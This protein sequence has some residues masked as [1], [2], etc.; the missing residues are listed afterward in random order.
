MSE[1]ANPPVRPPASQPVF[2]LIPHT[3]WDREWYLT[4]AEF[5]ARLVPVMEDLLAGLERDRTARCVLDGQTILLRD[6]L[7]TAP[8]DEARIAALVARG[9]LEIGPW[10]VL[11]DLLIPSGDSLRKNLELGAL[12]CARFGRRLE[13]LYS[14]DAFGH[15]GELPALA[16][17]F[18]L[19]RA[20]IRRGL[21]R[22]GG[23]DLDRYRWTTP[24]G[25]EVLVHHLPAGGYDIAIDL[26]RPSADLAA[27]WAALRNE[28]VARAGGGEVAV[29]LGAD[30]HAVPVTAPVLAAALRGIDPALEIRVSGLTEYF[31]ALEGAGPDATTIQGELR[32]GDGHTWVLPGVHSARAR[33]K[34][35]HGD[36]ELQL[37]RIAEPL[38]QL[39]HGH[40]GRDQDGLLGAAWRTLLECQFHDT[41]AGTTSDAVQ[42]EQEVRLATVQAIAG[43]VTAASVET[44]TGVDPDRIRQTGEAGVLAEWNPCG[45]ARQGIRTAELVFFRRDVLVGAPSGRIP[46]QGAGFAG[47]TLVTADGG[48]LPIQALGVQR[49]QH[50][51]DAMYAY[52]DQ[53]EVDR[54]WIAYAGQPIRG[55]GTG[56]LSPKPGP[57][58]VPDLL[59][60]AEPGV[61]G[62]RYIN[63]RVARNGALTIEDKRNGARLGELGECTDEADAGDLYTFSSGGD[64]PIRGGR[65]VSQTVM[66]AGPLVGAM[67]TRWEMRS[68]GDGEIRIRQLV[69]VY[70]DSPIVRIRLEIE[71]EATGHRLRARF[72]VPGAE[73]TLAGTALGSI[74]RRLDL[75]EAQHPS[76]YLPPAAPAHRYVA[77]TAGGPG[78]AVLSPGF[79]E[80]AW[81]EDRDVSVTLLR[82]VGEL[83]RDGLPERPGHAAWPTATP[84]AQEPGL[85]TIHLALVP[86][87]ASEAGD[88]ARLEEL[89]EDAFLPVQTWWLGPPAGAGDVKRET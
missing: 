11:S 31:E 83:S 42:R 34:R 88:V 9:A 84:D 45:R 48:M 59:L 4:R 49:G 40:G 36:V 78:V 65:P 30:H 24:G 66:A 86:I 33:L 63:V 20:V 7:H 81:D 70:A 19:R 23:R 52:P 8:A 35:R 29:F 28:L 77:M 2:H 43:A 57:A 41:L 1:P 10:Y 53:D 74:T 13:V 87:L 56:T 64:R 62:N 50:R 25:A 51:S 89:W 39:A 16:A 58:L 71:N 67:D 55:F 76:E 68:A 26:M 47:A 32:R 80:Y 85:H 73:T 61:V 46:R 5:K 15:P 60:K 75:P 82:A 14:P 12:D 44:L 69:L 17:E 21:G 38:A 27:G 22:P 18:G 3:H 72:P 37:A 79:F 6:Y 54:V